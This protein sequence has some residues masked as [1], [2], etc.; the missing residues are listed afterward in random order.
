[1][2]ARLRAGKKTPHLEAYIAWFN[3][4]SQLVASSTCLLKKKKQRVRVIGK[5][6]AAPVA[7]SLPDPTMHFDVYILNRPNNF[8]ANPGRTL[9]SFGVLMLVIFTHGNAV[10]ILKT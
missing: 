4:L 1:V 8:H 7:S 2:E 6:T 3:R 10:S 9:K 5:R